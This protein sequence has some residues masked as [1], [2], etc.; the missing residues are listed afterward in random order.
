MVKG[1]VPKI[2][3]DFPKCL[4]LYLDITDSLC[5]NILLT[6]FVIYGVVQDLP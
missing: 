1:I 5:Q 4:V 2:S 6:G 3:Q